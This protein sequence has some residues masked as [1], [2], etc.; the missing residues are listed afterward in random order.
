MVETTH[1]NASNDLLNRYAQ[2]ERLTSDYQIAKRLGVS[3]AQISAIRRG[4]SGLG[5]TPGLQIAETLGLPPLETIAKLEA[6][7]APTERV[8]TVWAKYCARVLLA[9]LGAS[10]MMFQTPPAEAE[11]TA[12]NV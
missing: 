7:R 12:C 8:K 10:W 1:M 9:A 4:R 3:R 11:P 2:V 5:N 6:E